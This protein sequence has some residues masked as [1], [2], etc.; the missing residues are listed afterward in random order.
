[1]TVETLKQKTGALLAEL[2]ID[3]AALSGD[4][5]VRSPIDGSV[6]A[7]VQRHDRGDLDRMVAAA[8]RAFLA[9]R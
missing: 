8:H 9:W 5:N 3:I 2:G 4:L 6:I 7:A 1:M